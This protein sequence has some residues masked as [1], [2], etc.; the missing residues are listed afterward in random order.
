MKLSLGQL[1]NMRSALQ[2]LVGLN[3]RSS[4][5]VRIVRMVK[6]LEPELRTVLEQRDKLI[7]K[8][9]EKKGEQHSIS[10]EM[11]GF[12]KWSAAFAEVLGVEVD[13]PVEPIEL[14][15]DVSIAPSVLLSLE[16]LVSVVE[17]KPLRGPVGL[18]KE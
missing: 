9:G 11:L 1:Y 17:E 4:L 8:Y 15:G 13:L 14:P 18:V 5:A 6:V 3:V 16:P 10:P 7:V 12:K 2:A